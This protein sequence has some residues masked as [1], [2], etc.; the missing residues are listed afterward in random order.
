MSDPTRRHPSEPPAS[1]AAQ[2]L[3][4]PQYRASLERLSK[5]SSQPKPYKRPS[6]NL[7]SPASSSMSTPDASQPL[8]SAA[9]PAVIHAGYSATHN[10]SPFAQSQSVSSLN[11]ASGS[12]SSTPPDSPSNVSV[13]SRESAGSADRG[14]VGGVLSQKLRLWHEHRTTDQ[15]FTPTNIRYENWHRHHYED[16]YVG[17]HCHPLQ[18]DPRERLKRET[19]HCALCVCYGVG[20]AVLGTAAVVEGLRRCAVAVLRADGRRVRRRQ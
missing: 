10:P 1:S 13:E 4:S 2:P 20:C 3:I 11:S 12:S 6:Y 9:V 14:G 17:P 5:R 18:L 16:I 7:S 19:I 8:L 15:D